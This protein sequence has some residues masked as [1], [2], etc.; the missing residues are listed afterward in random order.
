MDSTPSAAANRKV[1]GSDRIANSPRPSDAL[2][3]KIIQPKMAV[4]IVH[5]PV[6]MAAMRNGLL[7]GF[8]SSA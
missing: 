7:S 8:W 3:E 1:A 5:A 2:L 6:A 4:M